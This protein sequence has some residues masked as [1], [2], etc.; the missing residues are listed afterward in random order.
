MGWLW[1]RTSKHWDLADVDPPWGNRPS[2]YEHISRHVVPGRAGLAEGGEDLPDEHDDGGIRWS[3]GAKDGVFGHHMGTREEK[4]RAEEVAKA[5]DTV[6]ARATTRNVSRL[7]GLLTGEG[8]INHLDHLTGALAAK[9]PDLLR[10]GTLASWLAREAP[11]REPVKFAIAMLGIV[12]S[13]DHEDLL[14]TLGRHEEFTLYAAAALSSA[15]TRPEQRLFE[16]ARNVS[17][18]GRIHVVERLTGTESPEI[19]SWMLREGYKNSVMYEYLAFACA[20]AGGLRVALGAQTVDDDLLLGAGDII[21]ALISGGPAENMDDYA[22]GSTVVES[23]VGHL[24]P[25]PDN[26]RHFLVLASIR[27]FLEEHVAWEERAARGWTP[28]LRAQL[29]ERVTALMSLPH[30][31][32][33]AEQGLESDDPTEF[34]QA[35]QAAR[36]LGL[37]TWAIH[38]E[39]LQAGKD[40]WFFVM[41]TGDPR[42]IDQVVALAEERL[43]LSAIASGPRKELGM[44]PEWNP[45][46]QL[47]F[48]LQ[49][50]NRFPGRGWALLRT[51][52]RSPVVNN[53]HMALRALSP[54]GKSTWPEGAEALLTRALEDEPDAEVRAKIETLLAGRA[55]VERTVDLHDR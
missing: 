18:W 23:Y 53:R 41:Q 39:R 47:S 51:G 38:F 6:L 28:T 35:D 33:L 10:L 21:A 13:E 20:T 8:L 22:D 15:S 17:G 5:L 24:G 45:H 30:W 29:R 1:S 49:E 50:L 34:F 14:M 9:H 4:D 3:P 12:P 16:L 19:K 26:L 7:Y 52:I 25:R 55:I 42:R 11:D 40:E 32:A 36:T 46:R 43:P 37:D 48:V 31:Q 27:H 54:W 44:G 2:V